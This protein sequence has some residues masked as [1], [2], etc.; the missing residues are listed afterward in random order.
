M[1]E[2]LDSA[3][4]RECYLYSVGIGTPEGGLMGDD[5]EVIYQISVDYSGTQTA[6]IYSD[7]T[8]G[9]GQGDIIESEPSESDPGDGDLVAWWGVYVSS[10]Y[11]IEIS[12]VTGQSFYYTIRMTTTTQNTIVTE[13][14]ADIDETG[15]FA[16]AGDM[17]FSLYEDLNNIDIFASESSEWADLRGQYEKMD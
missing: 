14:Y 16:M 7:F 8:G 5:Y 11:A 1:L 15:Y 4:G 3:D 2:F 9:E 13:G 12:E 17:G 10:G 6:A